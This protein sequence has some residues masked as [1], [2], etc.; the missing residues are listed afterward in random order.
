MSRN[1][2]PQGKGG[3]VVLATLAEQRSGGMTV[4]P[5]QIDQVSTELFT[6]LFVLESRFRF[7]PV[8][9]KHYFLYGSAEKFWLGLTPPRMLG[10]A[11]AG[12]FIGT[13]VLRNDMTWTLELSDAVAADTE[14]IAYLEQKRAAF[15]EC[16]QNAETVD[17]VLPIYQRGFDFYRRASAFAVAHSLGRSMTQ[18]G[19]SGL[20]YEEARGLLTDGR[21]DDPD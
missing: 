11:V 21:G 3:S 12:R 15:E 6:S 1:P 16:L 2:N 19:I 8:P 9:G 5:K 17:D 10:E 14:F 4:P 7:K 18:A 13:C 20:S